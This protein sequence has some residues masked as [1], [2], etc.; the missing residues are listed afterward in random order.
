MDDALFEKIKGEA[1]DAYGDPQVF[2]DT[3]VGGTITEYIIDEVEFIQ[4]FT[5]T[6]SVTQE[7]SYHIGYADGSK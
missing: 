6:D 5:R 2:H 7:K 3:G 1:A 4:F